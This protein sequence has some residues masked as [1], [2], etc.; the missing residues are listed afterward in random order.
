MN[1]DPCPA[2]D[3]LRDVIERAVRS[4]PRTLQADLGP[5]ELGCGCDRC[6]AHL[7]AG[8]AKHELTLP[9]LPTIGNAVHDWLETVVLR[10]L[11][12]TGSARYLPEVAVTVG[13]LRGRDVTGHS[14]LYDVDTGTVI[15]W[16]ITG[17]TTLKKVKA[18]GPTDTY[19]RQAHL[20]GKGI[21]ALGHDVRHVAIVFLPR[22]AI[23]IDAGHVWTEPYDQGVA[24]AALTRANAIAAGI[25]A[26]G[27][28]TVLQ[29]M[30][31]HTGAEFTCTS[32]A[33][34]SSTA[35]AAEVTPDAFL[36]V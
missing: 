30:P 10:H 7:L 18:T 28:D 34:D 5:S 15:D 22:N 31:A 21:T 9:W 2:W 20:Y 3:D 17:A 14:D 4:N 8:H 36:G 33:N 13:Q 19:R 32:W 6:L 24:D 12:D 27:I 16:K 26:L 25:D 23:S 35:P 29:Q 1:G 11:G